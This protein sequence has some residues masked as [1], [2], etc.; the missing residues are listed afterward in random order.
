MRFVRLGNNKKIFIPK[1]KIGSI[2]TNQI[3]LKE[4][5]NFFSSFSNSNGLLVDAGAGERPYELLYREKFNVCLAFDIDSQHLKKGKF[6]FRADCAAIPLKNNTADAVLCTE[7][8]E[9]TK[10]PQSV[11]D[12]FYRICRQD[13]YVFL[14]TPFMKGIHEDP[15]DYFRFTE[16]SLRLLLER[17]GFEI[18]RIKPRGDIFGVL[19]YFV[20]GTQAK[21]W[22][23]IARFLRIKCI[24]S[25][26]NPIVFLFIYLPQK[27]YLFVEEVIS[28]SKIKGIDR[29]VKR[30][31]RTNLGYT[32]VAR[33]D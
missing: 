23:A 2:I 16:F 30:F 20:A 8:L 29:L 24:F 27:I 32:V 10:D 31:S 19:I 6:A 9:H 33:K 17:S 1:K 11:L 15:N 3:I 5:E 26:W 28:C 22:H 13:S 25:T 21:F 12:E 14:S 4:V 18:I 7:V